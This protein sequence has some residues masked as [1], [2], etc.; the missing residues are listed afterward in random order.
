MTKVLY[1]DVP[2]SAELQQ[3]LPHLHRELDVALVDEVR[4]APVVLEEEK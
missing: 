4:L 3:L 2:G 1:L